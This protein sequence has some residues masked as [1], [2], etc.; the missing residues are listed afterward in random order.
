MTCACFI[1]LFL[2][3]SVEGYDR[4][5]YDLGTSVHVRVTFEELDRL[6]FLDLQDMMLSNIQQIAIGSQDSI[7]YRDLDTSQKNGPL[8]YEA[9][10]LFDFSPR[11]STPAA[12]LNTAISNDPQR[13]FPLETF[14]MYNVTFV[15]LLECTY[16]CGD[17]G[18][19]VPRYTESS[20]SISCTCSCDSGWETDL[21]QP[22][23]SFKYCAIQRDSVSSSPIQN[24]VNGSWRPPVPMYPPPPPK[25]Y[26]DKSSGKIPLFKWA[27]IGASIIVTGTYQMIWIRFVCLIQTLFCSAGAI[28]SLQDSVLW[29]LQWVL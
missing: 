21:N 2:Q 29:P 1:A 26:E 3:T 22:F 17:H 24:S 20:N 28:H 11:D 19:R 14:G 7:I 13:A 5:L 4:S 27:I 15:G 6:S 23:E 10:V 9:L 16:P 8:G 18:V 25:T 12:L